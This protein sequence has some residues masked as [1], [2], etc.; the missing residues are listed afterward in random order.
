MVYISLRGFLFLPME[1]RNIAIIAHPSTTS[2]RVGYGA[3]V[4]HKIWKYGI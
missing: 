2:L 4:D 3:G 1:I